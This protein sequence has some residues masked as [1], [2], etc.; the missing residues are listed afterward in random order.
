MNFLTARAMWTPTDLER[1]RSNASM[2]ASGKRSSLRAR[3]EEQEAQIERCMERI[4]MLRR[5][6]QQDTPRTAA[7]R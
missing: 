1:A 2:P 6:L 4:R 5:E 7:G 3:I